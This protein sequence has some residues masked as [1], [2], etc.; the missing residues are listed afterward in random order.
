MDD[1]QNEALQGVGMVTVKATGESVGQYGFDL[2]I[3]HGT[4]GAPYIALV[5][6]IPVAVAARC[7]RAGLSLELAL[8]D[9]RRLE[10]FVTSVGPGGVEAEA[11]GSLVG[12]RA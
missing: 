8:D 3:D 2:S 12:P 10:F 6:D 1:T 11:V 9:G 7:Q 4:D 5:V